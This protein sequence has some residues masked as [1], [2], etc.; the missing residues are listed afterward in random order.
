VDKKVAKLGFEDRVK[1]G[2]LKRLL[3]INENDENISLVKDFNHVFEGVGCI[4]GNYE[5]KLKDNLSQ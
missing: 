3:E 2:I 1:L 5:I 4:K